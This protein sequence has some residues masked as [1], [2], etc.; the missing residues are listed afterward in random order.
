MASTKLKIPTIDFCNLELKPNTP[1]WE[2][3]KVQVFEA[4]KE[5]GCFEAIY[6]KIPN[7]IREA[8]FDTSK[9]TF[10]FPTSKLIEY[11]EKPF[12]IYE[13]QLPNL[14]LFGSVVSAD[15]L[16]PNSVETF[17]NTFWPNGNP[18]FC[19]VAKSFY[20]PI[21]ELDEMV[22]RMILE[23]L[24]L[25]NYIDEFLDSNISVLRF[26]KYKANEPGLRAHT[27]GN[28]ISIIKQ[29]QVGLQVLHKNGEWIEC[30]A[31]PNSYVVLV[32]DVMMALSN[33]RLSSAHHKI[34]VTGNNNRF[35]IQV[36]STVKPDYIVKVPKEL[37]NEE[38]PLLFKPFKMLDF[39]NYTKSGA[40]NGHG[41]KN[42]CGL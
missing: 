5:F 12:H 7:E 40:K 34:E 26:I 33:G 28:C 8:M 4:L 14:P 2:S 11:R 21:M 29:H 15:L 39:Y 23:T 35:S 37:V 19:N 6:D 13:D 16:L 10:E 9:E 3:T 27:D 18:N 38:Y 25:E 30:N 32:A 24:E 22:K 41:L 36:F 42:F 1:Q 17:A 20:K 31:S